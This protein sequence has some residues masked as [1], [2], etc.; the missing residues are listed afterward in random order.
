MNPL[1]NINNIFSMV[2]QHEQQIKVLIYDDAKILINVVDCN[3]LN[4]KT[5]ILSFTYQSKV[6]PPTKA[7]R[8]PTFKK[9]TAENINVI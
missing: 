1:S 2:K 5:Y 4:P 8:N 6:S 9:H 3:T 7:L